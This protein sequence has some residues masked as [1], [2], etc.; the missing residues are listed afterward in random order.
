L[1]VKHVQDPSNFHTKYRR[2]WLREIWLPALEKRHPGGI[3]SLAGSL[4]KISDAFQH[5]TEGLN[6]LV[7]YLGD[8]QNGIDRR[9][10]YCLN[11]SQQKQVLVNYLRLMGTHDFRHTQL[12]EI[13]K[14]L[15][16]SRIVHKF[17]L[18][19]L[20]WQVNAQQILASKS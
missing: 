8:W 1:K 19:N 16:S 5:Q 4:E 3:K 12:Q 13:I 6:T 10:F 15:D 20:N 18:L 17:K 7:W 2:N 14:H 9:Q 11:S